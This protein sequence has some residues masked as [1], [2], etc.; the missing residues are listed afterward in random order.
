MRCDL[1]SRILHAARIAGAE[2]KRNGPIVITGFMGCGKSKVARALALRRNVVLVDLDYWITRRV[3]RSPAQLINEE[4]ERAFREIETNALRELLQS[5]EAGVIALGGGAWIE[6]ANR[7]LIEQFSCTSIWLDT[8]FEICW[9]RIAASEEDR[10]LGRTREEAQARYDRRKPI[11]E[12][13]TVH[14]TVHSEEHVDDLI[15]L[16]EVQLDTDER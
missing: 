1:V 10:P 2:M 13:A 3:G 7:E 11:Y 5:G 6:E 12:L 8:P 15:S 9:E 16:I 4:G 14:I